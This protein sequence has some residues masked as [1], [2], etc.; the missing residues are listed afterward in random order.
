MKI[1]G[2]K[3]Q[4]LPEGVGDREL[5]YSLKCD[6]T[7]LDVAN[8]IWYAHLDAMFNSDASSKVEALAKALAK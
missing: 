6:P 7:D 5:T 3:V 1:E 2:M 4:G 8:Q